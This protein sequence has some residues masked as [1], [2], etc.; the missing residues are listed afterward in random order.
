MNTLLR[1]LL[2]LLILAITFFNGD[3][4]L[5]AIPQF[6]PHKVK[7]LSSKGIYVTSSTA[8]SK[9]SLEYIKNIL[10]TRNLDTIVLDVNYIIDKDIIPLIQ[11]KK[12]HSDTQLKPNTWLKNFTDEM[13][14]L[15]YI[16]TAR[17]VVFKDDH[18]IIARP[19]LSVM[20]PGGTIMRDRK[21]GHWV[22]PYADEARLYKVAMSEVAALSG[23]DEIQ[24]DY[25]RFPVEGNAKYTVFPHQKKD[26][27]RVGIICQFLEETKERLKPY[28]VSLA[29]D[30]F[31]VA[32][33]Q[34]KNDVENLG[35]DLKLMAK[36][37]DILSPMLYPSH[38]HN[39][40]DGFANPGSE[41]YYFLNS[42]V[43]RSLEI[44]SGEATQLAPWIQGFNMRSPNYGPE[45][46]RAQVKA[47]R[48]AGVKRFLIWNARNNYDVVPTDLN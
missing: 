23:V 10:K 39:G 12:L 47:C 15:G 43:K 42:G 38:F 40:Y 8:Q 4:L 20:N 14:K 22:D 48:D 5:K 6:V 27:S 19:D 13:H 44:L 37:L 36:Y 46:I 26:V 11:E 25:I 9:K 45:Y 2:A 18:L 41:P 24:F 32:A 35:Q 29:V 17:I 7:I 31:G 28:N 21:G 16:V 3:K 1:A 33:W 30:I 34:S